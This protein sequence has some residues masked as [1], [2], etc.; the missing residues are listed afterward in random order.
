[1]RKFKIYTL[2]TL[3]VFLF[4]GYFM[5]SWYTNNVEEKFFV[6]VYDWYGLFPKDVIRDFEKETGIKVRYDVYDSNEVLEAKLMATNSGYDVVFPSAS[7]YVARQI[8]GGVYQKINKAK[9][10]NLKNLNPQIVKE[11]KII[12][13][14]MDYALPYYWGSLG[15]LMDLRKV[16][17][18]IANPKSLGYKLIL[19][20]ENMKKLSACGVS[21]LEEA[22]D[23][24]P[25]VLRYL[26]KD[27]NSQK[28]EDLEKTFAILMN[29]RPF[30]RRFSSS[31]F[32]NDIA[33]GDVC[34][35]QAWSGESLR[36][37]ELGRLLGREIIY[38]I[39]KEGSSLWID[40]IAIPEG[41]PHPNNA[42]IFINFI[43]RPD[44]SARITNSNKIPTVIVDG[45]KLVEKE[46]RENQTIFP[47]KEILENLFIDKPLLTPEAQDFDRKRTRYWARVRL[48]A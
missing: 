39:P 26:G 14:Q 37:Q 10:S 33:M 46:I 36:A 11:M 29:V 47:P 20:P 19:D 25:A 7:P 44:I 38:Y 32:I 27:G 45:Y 30:I 13:P 18:L 2:L 41:A 40:C 43:L 6:N 3:S 17:E 22:I 31:R 21:F 48:N 8:Q 1:M 4:F 34:L 23:V 12:D 9:L 5:F 42:H 24:F 16:S 15:I 35:A 28:V